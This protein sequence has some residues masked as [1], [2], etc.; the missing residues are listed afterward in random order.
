MAYYWVQLGDEKDE[1]I[2]SN[3]YRKFKGVMVHATIS[4]EG[5][6]TVDRMYGEVNAESSSGLLL[7]E[8]IP[9]IHAAH[10]TN[11][12]YQMDNASI[13]KKK[14]IIEYLEAYGFSFLNY[15]ALSP[16][17]NPVENFSTLLVRRVYADGKSYT[18]EDVL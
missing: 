17:L 15:P 2:Y 13:N 16:D 10:G 4:K 3:D 5:L 8:V 6:H 14:E 18:N 12:V 9:S 1:V 11:F 7:S